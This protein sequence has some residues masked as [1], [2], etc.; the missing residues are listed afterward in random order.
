MVSL[1]RPIISKSKSE[2][3]SWLSGLPHILTPPCAS[4]LLPSCS[5]Y[6][7]NLGLF[8]SW[9]LLINSYCCAYLVFSPFLHCHCLNKFS[10]YLKPRGSNTFSS[11]P[12]E[13]CCYTEVCC[14]VRKPES[15]SVCVGVPSGQTHN[16][17]FQCATLQGEKAALIF[18][19]PPTL[20]ACVSGPLQCFSEDAAYADARGSPINMGVIPPREGLAR[21]MGEFSHH[22]LHRG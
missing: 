1:L 19:F 9:W 10:F 16:R 14:T 4:D 17:S 6:F 2:L 11:G 13:R 5:F 21:L 22:S 3:L 7:S 18:Q 8:H 12:L 15:K 20:Q